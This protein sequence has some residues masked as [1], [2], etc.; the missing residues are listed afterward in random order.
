ML[1]L[2]DFKKYPRKK[3]LCLT[4]QSCVSSILLLEKKASTSRVP[5]TPSW[6]FVYVIFF[7]FVYF[8]LFHCCDPED[9]LS[10]FPG[11]L[12]FLSA[13]QASMPP[14]VSD[15]HK[16]FL[17]FWLKKETPVCTLFLFFFC[18]FC[19]CQFLVRQGCFCSV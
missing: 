7:M 2:N 11:L 8:I 10:L 19:L 3:F 5:F 13:S 9:A 15:L 4:K 16:L 12:L 14:D 6:I 1:L 18:F 17:H